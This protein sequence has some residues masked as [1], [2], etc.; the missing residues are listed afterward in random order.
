V[1]GESSLG[2]FIFLATTP[3]NLRDVPFGLWIEDRQGEEYYAPGES[4]Q[5]DARSRNI[6]GMRPQASEELDIPCNVLVFP[7]RVR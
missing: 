2:V 1:R 4:P 3:Q 5:R 7:P 6:D